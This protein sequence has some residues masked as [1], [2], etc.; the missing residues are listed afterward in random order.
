M[1]SSARTLVVTLTTIAIGGAQG[2]QLPK[3]TLPVVDVSDGPG[4]GRL[5]ILT[6]NAEQTQFYLPMQFGEGSD[7]VEKLGLVS[8]TR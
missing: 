3:R 7:A 2:L 6:T 8:T 5:N 4:P 1:H